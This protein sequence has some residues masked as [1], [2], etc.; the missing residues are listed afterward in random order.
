M[1][2]NEFDRLLKEQFDQHEFAYSPAN[3]EKLAGQ[4]PASGSRRISILPW[5]KPVALAAGLALLLGSVAVF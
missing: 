2:K 3:W 1:S 4:L 5:L